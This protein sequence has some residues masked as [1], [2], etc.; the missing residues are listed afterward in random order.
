MSQALLRES[1]R[2]QLECFFEDAHL[3]PGLLLGAE[4]MEVI[5]ES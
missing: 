4:D 3:E 2:Q 5:S 1:D